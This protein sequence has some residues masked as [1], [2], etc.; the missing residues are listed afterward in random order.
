MSAQIADLPQAESRQL[1]DLEPVVNLW[2]RALDADLPR[3]EH[4]R[5][6]FFQVPSSLRSG[7][8]SPGSA[9]TRS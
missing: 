7:T 8:A 3:A 1:A 5:G 2:Q 4:G 6:E 9:R